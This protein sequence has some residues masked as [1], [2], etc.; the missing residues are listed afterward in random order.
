MEHRDWCGWAFGITACVWVGVFAGYMKVW[1]ST[2]FLLGAVIGPFAFRF[3]QW[4]IDQKE[5]TQ[6]D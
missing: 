2:T 5:A 4:L 6:E 3:G 1:R